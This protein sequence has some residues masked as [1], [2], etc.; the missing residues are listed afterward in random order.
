MKKEKKVRLSIV[1]DAINH[2]IL[3][4][5]CVNLGVSITDFVLKAV[6]A[7]IDT[8][9]DTNEKEGKNGVDQQK[10]L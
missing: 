6:D 9:G 2:K 4:I 5:C 3:K 7:A 10:S 8:Y 1:M